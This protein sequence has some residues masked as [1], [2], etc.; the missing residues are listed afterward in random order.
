VPEGDTIFRA[1]ATLHRALAG[2]T[3]T[4]FDS[5][6][7]ALNRIHDDH[8]VTGRTIESVTSRGKHLLMTFSG[9]LVL[10]THMRLNG[11]WH[12]YRPGERWRRPA[13]EM[14]I[15][16]ETA[17]FVAVAFSV[18][19]AEW[20]TSH[21][22]AR[23]AELTA[24]GPDLLSSGFNPAEVL[25]RMRAH[26]ADAIADVLLNQ[27]ILAGIGNVFK[28]EVLFLTGFDPFRTVATLS[29]DDLMRIIDEGV[30][31]LRAN[32][33]GRDRTLSPAAGRRT[34]R[35]LDPRASLWVYGRAG[36]PCRRCGTPIQ[37]RKTG[38][39]ARLTF[40]CP[41]CQPTSPLRPR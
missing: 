33:L 1:A 22:L 13:R 38:L 2:S 40:W 35:S 23:H 4:R 10:R 16:V 11:S 21:S 27:R 29:D 9:D 41:R 12:I 34:T 26:G 25:R 18:P 19:I 3:V 6:F 39:D 17:R 36:L 28:S 32:V 5:A 37:S 15:L 7:P 8:P 31:Q 24:L 30:A 20:L 14:R